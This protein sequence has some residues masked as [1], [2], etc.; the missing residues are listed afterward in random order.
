MAV[1]NP[2]FDA[3]ALLTAVQQQDVGLEVSTNNPAGFRRLLYA[4][5]RAAPALRC[6]V[7]QAP[8]SAN[9]FW[10]CKSPAPEAQ[11]VETA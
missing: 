4:H 3:G 10:L 6:H 8:D 11:E 2:H 5:M 7:Y 1:S 9:K